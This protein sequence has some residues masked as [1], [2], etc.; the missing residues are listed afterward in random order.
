MNRLENSEE[1]FEKEW[2]DAMEEASVTPPPAVWNEIDRKLA[3]AELSA[4]K[5]KVVY[6]RWAVAAVILLGMFVGV[7]QYYYFQNID[8]ALMGD[9]IEI[10]KPGPMSSFEWD[11]RNEISNTQNGFANNSEV[12][13]STTQE[14]Q[15]GVKIPKTNN[16]SLADF[17]PVG[18]LGD[19]NQDINNMVLLEIAAIKGDGIA[20]N[21]E[22]EI[23]E[24]TKIPV[25]RFYSDDQIDKQKVRDEKYFAGINFGSGGFDPNFQSLGSSLLTN[26]LEVNPTAFSLA[27]NEAI[28]KESPSIREGMVAGESMSLG[29]DF[30]MKVGKRFTLESGI[31]YARANAV[32]ETNVVITTSSWQESIAATSQVSK[33]KKFS[34]VVQREEIV[35]YEYRDV[36]LTNEF[37]FTSVPLTAG[38][39]VLDKKL[40][41]EVNAGVVANLYM[42]NK[43]TGYEDEIAQL[44]IGPGSQSPYR[45]ISFSGLAGLEIGYR[46][47]SNFDVIVEPNYRQALNSMTKDDATFLSNPSGFG[48]MTGIKYNFH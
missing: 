3:Y 6:Y 31:Q 1:K 35:E 2:R 12:Y 42:G 25:F 46:L 37:Q 23:S 39:Q 48:V 36:A 22:G 29:V 26:N 34:S 45:D 7:W 41:L 47:F 18:D 32:T 19:D 15:G 24:P 16:A 8:Q 14:N 44:S 9:L 30:G 17:A 13:K 21:L 20:V 10:D 33:N 27:D 40:K 43:L 38:Y 28:N 4:Y 5:S 11:I